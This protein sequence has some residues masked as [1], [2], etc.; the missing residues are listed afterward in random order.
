MASAPSL[1]KRTSDGLGAQLGA[2]DGVEHVVGVK[3][4]SAPGMARLRSSA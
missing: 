1:R 3:A 4:T 2:T